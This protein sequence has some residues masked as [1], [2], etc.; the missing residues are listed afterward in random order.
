MIG[1]AA[2]CLT[3][4]PMPKEA[5]H[6]D[7]DLTYDFEASRLG[8]QVSC[9]IQGFAIMLGLVT[10]F[11]YNGTLIIYYAYAIG[12]NWTDTRIRHWE[13]F[14]FHIV[15]VTLGLVMAIVPWLY[16]N[17]NPSG[18]GISCAMVVAQCKEEEEDD[19]AIHGCSSNKERGNQHA[20]NSTMTILIVLVGILFLVMFISFAIILSNVGFSTKKFHNENVFLVGERKHVNQRQHQQQQSQKMSMY[21]SSSSGTNE[22]ERINDTERYDACSLL[23]Q[24]VAYTIPLVLSFIFQGVII[25]DHGYDGQHSFHGVLTLLSLVFSSLQG[26]FNMMDFFGHKVYNYRRVF[27]NTGILKS[28]YIILKSSDPDP[29]LITGLSLVEVS[30]RRILHMD[31]AVF[32]TSGRDIERRICKS[33]SIEDDDINN[34]IQSDAKLSVGNDMFAFHESQPSLGGFSCSI[35]YA[36]D[37]KSDYDA[38]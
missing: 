33:S 28:I 23:V 8:N 22:D 16:H 36:E 11:A 21:S 32:L 15:P 5:S 35:C 34:E 3:S 7:S 6:D 18:L 10:S 14:L 30:Q 13:P 17:Y 37:Y 9:E 12:L 38:P 24:M 29:I 2:I 31:T 4:I 26:F 1:S 20:F 27:E 25:V 19:E